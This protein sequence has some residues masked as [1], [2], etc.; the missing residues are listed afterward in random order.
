[1]ETLQHLT[2][3]IG[4]RL[5]G[6]PAMRKANDWAAERLR[7]YG[8]TARLEQYYFGVTWERGPAAFRLTAPFTRAMTG[9]SWAWT[10]GTGGKTLAGPVVLADLSTP[11][12]LAVYHARGSRAP[13]CS[14]GPRF[15][16]GTR[17]ARR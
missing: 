12:S 11:E 10:A 7:G 3:V 6:S 1:M 16:S 2:D 14:R 9:H 4:P 15:R 5:S 17:T 8:L 13:G